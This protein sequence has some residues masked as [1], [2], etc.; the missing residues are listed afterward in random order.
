MG[1][2]KGDDSEGAEREGWAVWTS[3]TTEVGDGF[4]GFGV[5]AS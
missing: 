2:M 4:E 5:K 3:W 1:E